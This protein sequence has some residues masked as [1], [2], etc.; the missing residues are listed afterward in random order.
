MSF[1]MASQ[2]TQPQNEEGGVVLHT[3]L[4]ADCKTGQYASDVPM[5]IGLTS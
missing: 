3:H 2:I 4:H 5:C 1:A